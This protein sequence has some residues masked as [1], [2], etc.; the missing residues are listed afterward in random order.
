LA[1]RKKITAAA[2][3]GDFESL[4]VSIVEIH[5]RALL[6]A[7][8]AVNLGLTLR[9]WL[10]GHRIVEFE[11][12]GQDRAAYGERLMDTLSERMA[13]HGLRRV[14]PRELRR[15][16]HLYQVIPRMWES[17][18]P[19]SLAEAGLGALLPHSDLGVAPPGLRDGRCLRDAPKRLE[20]A[21]ARRATEHR[22]TKTHPPTPRALHL[23]VRSGASAIIRGFCSSATTP[24]V[25]A[26]GHVLTP[27]RY[28]GADEVGEDGIPFDQRMQRLVA[29]LNAQFAASAKLEQA[30]KANLRGLGHG[31]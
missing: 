14:T 29:E 27:V 26:H 22:T 11:Q 25:A 6:L 21:A 16:R 13:T 15:F 31:G 3:Q 1:S 30:T 4:V 8:K 28:V 12:R 20:T 7:S 9:N 10:I 5:Q 17:V 19:Q 24:E 23:N 2:G 18:T